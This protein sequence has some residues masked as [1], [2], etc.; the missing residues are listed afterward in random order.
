MSDEP[1]KNLFDSLEQFEGP[2]ERNQPM[3]SDKREWTGVFADE[4]PTLEQRRAFWKKWLESLTWKGELE[5]NQPSEHQ[6]RDWSGV[7][8]DASPIKSEH[9]KNE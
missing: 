8:E 6:Q 5:R 1:W 2:I 3:E 4:Q 9:D 7:F